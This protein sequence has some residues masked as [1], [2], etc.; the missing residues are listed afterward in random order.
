M[1]EAGPA[2]VWRRTAR[3]LI[4]ETEGRLLLLNLALAIYLAWS[5][6]YFRRWATCAW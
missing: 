5:S 2:A 3:G 1:S 6:P 4:G